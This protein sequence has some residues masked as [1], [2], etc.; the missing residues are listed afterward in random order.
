MASD[1]AEGV[2]LCDEGV[3]VGGGRRLG[4][5]VWDLRDGEHGGGFLGESGGGEEGGEEEEGGGG[6]CGV[7]VGCCVLVVKW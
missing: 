2:G 6:V 7:H 5:A 4:L 3:G 1:D